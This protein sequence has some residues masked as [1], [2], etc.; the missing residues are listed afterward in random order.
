MYCFR[1]SFVYLI[2]HWSGTRTHRCFPRS[3]TVQCD[4]FRAYFARVLLVGLDNAGKTTIVKRVNGEDI[5]KISPTLGFDIKTLEFRGYRLNV[6]D[7]GGKDKIRPLLR[8][9]Y[10]GTDGIDTDI[11]HPIE[12]W[13]FHNGGIPAKIFFLFNQILFYAIRPNFV[14]D[15]A[16]D[17]WFV[18]NFVVQIAFDVAVVKAFGSETREDQRIAKAARLWHLRARRSWGRAVGSGGFQGV[19]VTVMMAGALT[20]AMWLWHTGQATTGDV[21][22][23]MSTIHALS[24]H[25]LNLAYFNRPM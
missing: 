24:V 19:M 5:S 15:Q 13:L 8:H 11:P 22:V 4:L 20:L 17:A 18:L 10:Q 3:A 7:V 14:R 21:V 25:R 23:I 12:A 16:V 2:V 9:Y 6:W 1:S